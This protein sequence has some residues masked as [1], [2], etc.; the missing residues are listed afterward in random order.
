MNFIE[1]DDIVN[2]K[3]YIVNNEVDDEINVFVKEIKTLNRSKEFL[4]ACLLKYN[5]DLD[6]AIGIL[7]SLFDFK[8]ENLIYICKVFEDECTPLSII[9]SIILNTNG[10][11]LGLIITRIKNSID[12]KL[13]PSNFY[14][15]LYNISIENNCDS[16]YVVCLGNYLTVPK[17]SY[18]INDISD[19]TSNGDTDNYR[20][21]GPINNKCYMLTC[22]CEEEDNEEEWFNGTC[23]NCQRKIENKEYAVRFPLRDGCWIGCYCSFNCLKKNSPEDY[24]E[25]D[26][27]KIK[28]IEDVLNKIGIFKN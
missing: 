18:I 16:I 21:Y 4:R 15:I 23:C 3:N 1:N 10:L 28:F 2:F 26:E 11:C 17:P 14:E 13:F 25:E 20:R 24:N 12:S 9:K 6:C 27:I 19:N 22:N 7:A 5:N 8:H